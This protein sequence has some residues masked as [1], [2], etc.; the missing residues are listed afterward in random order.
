[1][2]TMLLGTKAIV[3]LSFPYIIRPLNPAAEPNDAGV[4][5][6]PG[7]LRGRADDEAGAGRVRW[8]HFGP[9]SD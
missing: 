9:W 1:M 4:P 3:A 5:G 2:L 6:S 7:R 8:R